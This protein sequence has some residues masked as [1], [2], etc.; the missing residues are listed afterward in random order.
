[1]KIKRGSVVFSIVIIVLALVVL[2]AVTF[3]FPFIVHILNENGIESAASNTTVFSFFY[4]CVPFGYIVLFA[5]LKVAL[6]I[7]RNDIFTKS[8]L[9]ATK[10]VSW[11]TLALAVIGFVASIFITTF[12]LFG[13]S[14]L[15]LGVTVALFN[16]IIASKVEE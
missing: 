8:N 13:V 9:L 5:L 7:L 4:A 12:L 2:A 10:I 3:S 14:M 11:C 16:N 6:S 1:M 15:F